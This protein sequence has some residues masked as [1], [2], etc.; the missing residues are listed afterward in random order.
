MDGHLKTGISLIGNNAGTNMEGAA[1][2]PPVMGG[3]LETVAAN[4]TLS[5]R[6]RLN[7]MREWRA[8]W[9]ALDAGLAKRA[10]ELDTSKP[11]ERQ[12][13]YQIEGARKRL[14]I[15]RLRRPLEIDAAAVQSDRAYAELRVSL[16]EQFARLT[17]AEKLLWLDNLQ[18][19]M[20]PALRELDDKVSNIRRYRS[21][22]QRRNFLLGG[23]SGMGKSTYL[24]YLTALNFPV[25]EQTRNLVRVLKI[26]APVGGL[27]ARSLLQRLILE[28]GMTYL[29]SDNEEDLLLKL[30][31]YL[32]RCG[33]EV[34]VIDECE[35][36]SR[37]LLR[38]RLLEVSNLTHGVPIICASCRP[39][40][41]V[42]GD[43]EI[44]GRWND[45]YRIEPY[46]GDRLSDLLLFIELLLPFPE[47]SFLDLMKIP[48]VKGGK[49]GEPTDG[50]AT[51]IGAW[52]GGILREIM[53]LLWD[54]SRRA[55]WQGL[56]NLPVELLAQTWAGI[57]S[58]PL[59]SPD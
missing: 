35:H 34:I 42:Q 15:W 7:E 38:R 36:I 55:I 41:W 39:H 9:Q 45:Y 4:S 48:T 23:E 22:G 54:A 26:D 16:R 53:V 6:E 49:A 17:K 13:G 29:R 24:N 56:S 46:K 31:I 44:A 21:M 52:T 5:V 27:S 30:V 18:F 20:T 57:R 14:E 59:P 28:C 10:L 43:V 51:L 58:Q 47:D 2:V 1:A 8:E 40:L 11:L 33:V 12:V 50:P 25:V 37:P 32:P 19:I 3:R